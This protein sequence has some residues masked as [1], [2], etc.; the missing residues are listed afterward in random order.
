MNF[1]R[2]VLRCVFT[3]LPGPI[4]LSAHAVYLESTIYEM[5]SDKAFISKRIYND[6]HKQNVYSIAAVKI[7]KPGP[8]GENRSAIAEGELLFTPLNFSLAPGAS[9]FFK[10]FYRGPQDGKERYYRIL[11][12]E[13]PVTLFTERS[14]GKGSEAVPVIAIDTI[15]VV[16]PGKVKLD[17][18][19]D[20][21]NGV[22]KNTGN[23]FFKIIVHQ[24]CHSTDDEATMRYVLPGETWRSSEL[25][26][27]N[28]KFIVALQKY[29]PVGEG[30]FKRNP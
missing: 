24:G 8:G 13:M 4:A 12:R 27:K 22:L 7:D 16:R 18:T 20:E 1:R 14:Q 3:L 19:I 15:L 23:T 28:K 21:K 30:C 2:F 11:F 5:P 29:I 17:Y 9:E 26:T 10:I 25:K 6:S